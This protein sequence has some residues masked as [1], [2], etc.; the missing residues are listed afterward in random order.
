MTETAQNY[1]FMSSL[2]TLILQGLP[3]SQTHETDLSQIPRKA[4]LD[5]Q[6]FD[7]RHTLTAIKL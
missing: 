3:V 5:N 4:N 7:L 2:N 6:K 1:S